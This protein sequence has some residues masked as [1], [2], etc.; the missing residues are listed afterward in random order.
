L[1]SGGPVCL[2]VAG[3]SQ[4]VIIAWR[5]DNEQ[6]HESALPIACVNRAH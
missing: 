6:V 1:N 2:I 4:Q 3:D 5:D